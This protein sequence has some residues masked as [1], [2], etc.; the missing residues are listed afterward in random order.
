M[1]FPVGKSKISP[2]IQFTKLP[3]IGSVMDILRKIVFIA[4]VPLL[5]PGSVSLAASTYSVNKL[6]K[7]EIRMQGEMFRQDL[8]INSMVI[9]TSS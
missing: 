1:L 3:V 4:V 8:V 2:Q 5:L 6:E 9:L 7:D